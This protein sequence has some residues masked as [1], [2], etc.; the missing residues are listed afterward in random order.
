MNKPVNPLR[1]LLIGVVNEH[2]RETFAALGDE[3][4]LTAHDQPQWLL[5]LHL[6]ARSRHL[7]LDDKEYTLR[8]FE[9]NNLGIHF[10]YVQ[11]TNGLNILISAV[12]GEGQPVPNFKQRAGTYPLS[13][14]IVIKQRKKYTRKTGALTKE[15]NV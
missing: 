11:S 12:D 7:K 5:R 4:K 13:L 2:L 14:P 6:I 9:S 10:R 3:P 1:T 15:N 8:P